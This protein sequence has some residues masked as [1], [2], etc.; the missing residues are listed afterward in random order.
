SHF[1]KVEEYNARWIADRS[2]M[3]RKGQSACMAID[4]E[5]GDVV[6][7]LIA[8]VKEPSGRVEIKA[9]WITSTGPFLPRER[10]HPSFANRECT[11]TVVQTVARVNEPAIAGN[12]NPRAEVAAGESG[13]KAGDGLPAGQPPVGCIVV[14]QDNVRTFFLE[15]VAP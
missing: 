10:Q 14:K 8:A 12:H 4:T 3:P 15:A 13:R 2:V 5:Y 7:S 11:N 6:P 1:C 9:A